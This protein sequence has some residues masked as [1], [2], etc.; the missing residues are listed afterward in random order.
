MQPSIDGLR[1]CRKYR[2]IILFAPRLEFTRNAFADLIL[3]DALRKIASKGNKKAIA[4]VKASWCCGFG[5]T[6]EPV[7]GLSPEL[8][9][10][11]A[12]PRPTP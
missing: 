2:K 3:A 1:R 6:L 4:D 9:Q 8:L 5:T 12:G 10:G 11:R 7:A